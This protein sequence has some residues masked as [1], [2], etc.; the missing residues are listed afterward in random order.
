MPTN[1]SSTVVVPLIGRN[2]ASVTHMIAVGICVGGKVHYVHSVPFQVKAMAPQ[3]IN[4]TMIEDRKEINFCC[5][6]GKGEMVLG[7]HLDKNAYASGEGASLTYEVNNASSS[8]VEKLQVDIIGTVTASAK[9][10]S[11]HR[12]NVIASMLCDPVEANDGFG[13]RRPE[14]GPAKTLTLR[15]PSQ[16]PYPTSS[17]KNLRIE[18]RVA[19][20]CETACCVTNPSIALPV[21]IY[22]QTMDQSAMIQGYNM[23]IENPAEQEYPLLV[24]SVVYAPDSNALHGT[25]PPAHMRAPVAIPV[26]TTGDGIAN[27]LGYDTTGDGKIDA[28]DTNRD[29]NIDM[30]LPQS[31]STPPMAQASYITGPQHNPQPIPVDTTGD[32]RPNAMGYD[33]T[34]DG[35]IDSLDTNKDGRIDMT[36]QQQQQPPPAYSQTDANRYGGSVVHP[37]PNGYGGGSYSNSYGGHYVNSVPPS[38]QNMNR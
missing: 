9:G 14:G 36:L 3:A 5:C 21:T 34:G 35:K 32:G 22:Q 37:D 7:A 26:D 10:H 29:G 15:V 38:S 6:F 19:V 8:K 17:T 25:A 20:S 1:A 23:E 33:T 31:N 16:I 30:R 24:A 11:F 2:S 27:A 13:S 12:T 4:P 28:L 18:Y